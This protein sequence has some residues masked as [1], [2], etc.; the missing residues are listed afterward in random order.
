MPFKFIAVEFDSS[1][2]TR[3]ALLAHPDKVD[4]PDI[5]AS[6]E[7][8]AKSSLVQRLHCRPQGSA[9]HCLLGQH[10]DGFRAD[11]GVVYDYD[12][13]LHAEFVHADVRVRRQWGRYGRQQLLSF[14]HVPRRELDDDDGQL[15]RVLSLGTP[16]QYTYYRESCC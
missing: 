8:V 2:T 7:H 15:R 14:F 12:V 13:L 10:P 5:A 3:P 16:R 9:V 1:R 4:E 11:L 6:K